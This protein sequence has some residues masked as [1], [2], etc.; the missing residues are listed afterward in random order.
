MSANLGLVMHAAQAHAHE[1]QTERARNALAERGLADTRRTDK[2]QNR[3]SALGI[4]LAY[5]QELEDAPLDLLQ[6]E[7]I[8][9]EDAP[10]P[11]DVEVF[12]VE[13]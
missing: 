9:I 13:L 10:C 11:L 1:L 12:G 2:A 3:A 5:G 4:E 6:P 8:L 7:M